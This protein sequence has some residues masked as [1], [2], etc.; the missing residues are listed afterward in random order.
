[1]DS[2]KQNSGFATKAIHSSNNPSKWGGKSA[3]TF[4]ENPQ[5]GKEEVFMAPQDKY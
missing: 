5:D 2:K 1:M 4:K 3:S